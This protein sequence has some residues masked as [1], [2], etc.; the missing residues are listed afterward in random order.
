[1]CWGKP[2]LP[3]AGTHPHSP[4]TGVRKHL[5]IAQEVPFVVGEATE[6]ADITDADNRGRP[7]TVLGPVIAVAAGLQ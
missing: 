3:A 7:P 6:K 4:Q 1:M 2:F 5:G